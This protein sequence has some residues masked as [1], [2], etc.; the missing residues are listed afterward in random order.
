MVK[1]KVAAKKKAAPKKAAFKKNAPKKAMPKKAA[2]KKS[3]TRAHAISSNWKVVCSV[4][5][6]IASGLTMVEAQKQSEDHQSATGHDTTY[7]GS[8]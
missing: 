4:Q 5:G 1:K 3:A 6:T 8:Q 7:V 2:P